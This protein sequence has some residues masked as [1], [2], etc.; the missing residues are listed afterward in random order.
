MQHPVPSCRVAS[1][2]AGNQGSRLLSKSLRPRS[3][4]LPTQGTP[5]P[6]NRQ[7]RGHSRMSSRP[8]GLLQA[9]L[10]TPVSPEGN[11]PAT[12]VTHGANSAGRQAT[13]DPW[14][15]TKYPLCSHVEGLTA[16][17]RAVCHALTLLCSTIIWHSLTHLC[18]SQYS[19]LS[20]CLCAPVDHL[21]QCCA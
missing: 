13:E 15:T 7:P 4:T 11:H 9:T 14:S 5:Q 8:P 21:Y 12:Y 1:P 16:S 10:P 17:G 3:A 20:Q 6:P 19:G 2:P 18:K